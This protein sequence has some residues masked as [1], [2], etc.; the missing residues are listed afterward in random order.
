[1][2]Q[3]LPGVNAQATITVKPEDVGTLLKEL[4]SIFGKVTAEPQCISVQVFQST[5]NP[6]VISLVE[7]WYVLRETLYENKH[8]FNTRYR[9]ESKEWFMEVRKAFPRCRR[10]LTLFY[11]GA[12]EERVL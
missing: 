1:M 12:S 8:A 5:D 7:N 3:L 2:S 11:V 4:Q 9:N 10:N 6:G